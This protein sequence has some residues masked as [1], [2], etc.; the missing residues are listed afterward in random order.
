MPAKKAANKHDP[1][2]RFVV[3]S[4]SRSNIADMLNNVID[5]LEGDEDVPKRFTADDARLTDKLCQEFADDVFDA[6][7]DDEEIEAAVARDFIDKF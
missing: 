6:S 2:Q 4:L 7:D 1:E 5:E 3:T